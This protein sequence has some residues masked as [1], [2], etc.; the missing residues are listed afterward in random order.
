MSLFVDEL[1]HILSYILFVIVLWV[2]SGFFNV[3]GAVLGFSEIFFLDL[4]HFFDYF[5]S[6]GLKLNL[7][8]FF[9][10][11]HFEKSKKAYV[12]LHSWEFVILLSILVLFSRVLFFR[13]LLLYVIIGLTVHLLYDTWSNRAQWYSYFLVGRVLHRFSKNLFNC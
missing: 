1:G 13:D 8:D 5:L 10:G 6:E 2:V 9:H 12:L 3:G 7:R 11:V 4:D